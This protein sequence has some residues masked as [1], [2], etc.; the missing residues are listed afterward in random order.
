MKTNRMPASKVIG[1][2]VTHEGAPATKESMVEKLDRLMTAHLLWEDQFYIDGVSNAKI[3][4]DHVMK[5]LENGM[6]DDIVLAMYRAKTEQKIRH[7]PLYVAAILAANYKGNVPLSGFISQ[8]I[9]RAD[10]LAEIISLYAKVIG[11]EPSEVR[12]RMPA[13]LKKGI[14]KAFLKFDEYQ[15]AKYDRKAPVTLLDAMRLSHPPAIGEN[16]DARARLARGELRTPDTWET[17]LS[18][19]A[20]K[21]ETFTRLIEEGRLG[22]TALL[23]N[24][25]NMRDAG[26]SKRLVEQAIMEN[27]SHWIN[28]FQFIMAGV[29]V[30]EF[31]TALDMKMQK[32][33]A[34]RATFDGKT[35]ILLDRSGSMDYGTAGRSKVNRLTVAG[36]LAACFNGDKHVAAF[37][38]GA[39]QH[40]PSNLEGFDLYES[41]IR[42]RSG[43]TDIGGAVRQVSDIKADRL[44]VLTDEQSY[45]RVMTGP[46]K[47][48]Y[49]VNIGSYENSVARGDGWTQINGWSDAIFDYIRQHEEMEGR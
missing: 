22:Y 20:D 25:R 9:V 39:L 24:L 13:Q 2:V 35:V 15:L 46:F 27:N 1:R 10:E 44:I 30:P 8:M 28:P 48:N 11:V 42:A 33:L 7:A 26:V 34:G 49:M 38:T 29:M 6:H 23:R 3:L 43:G 19:G 17:A 36:A 16:A 45:S 21:K 4:H 14:A 41:Y 12:K 47:Y 18:A 31:R 32:E 5:M 40:I 37:T